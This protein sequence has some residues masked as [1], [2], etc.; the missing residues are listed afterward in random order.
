[1]LRDIEPQEVFLDRLAQKK[2]TDIK[3]KF[4][5]A[6]PQ[7]NVSFFFGIIILLLLLAV[8]KSFQ[9][10]VLEHQDFSDLAK[11][12]SERVYQSSS[13]RGIIYDR[14]MVQLVWNK[15]A[16]DL[17]CDTR[18]LPENR[19]EIFSKISLILGKNEEDIRSKIEE[20]DFYQVE[21]EDNLS[22]EA[23]MQLEARIDEFKGFRIEENTVREYLD[24]SLSHIL[25]YTRKISEEELSESQGYAVTD[26][27]GKSGLEEWY[28]NELRGVPAKRIIQKDASGRKIGEV[29]VSEA[30]P[31]EN[32]VL[33]LDYGLQKKIVEELEKSMK[34]I[35]A[36]KAAAIAMDPETGGVLAL[37]SI[38]Y[39]DNNLFS[40]GISQEDWQDL[41]SSP[42]DPLFNKAVSGIGYPTG[43]TIKPIVGMAALEEGIISAET[44]ID[45]PS[46]VCIWNPY[47][48]KDEC[49]KDWTYPQ[50]HGVSDIKRAIAESVNPFFYIIGGGYEGFSGLGA[51]KILEYFSL[52]GMG[53]K[54]GIDLPSEGEGV[55]PEIDEDWRLGNTYHLSIGQGAFTA[56]PLEVSSALA[57]IANGGKLMKPSLVQK[58]PEII[59]ENFVDEGNI[60]TIREGMRQTVSSGSAVSLNSLAVEAAAKTGTA[61][62]SLEGHYHHWI[63]VF[64][65]YEDPEIILTLIIEDVEGIQ[66]VTLPAAKEILDWYF[67]ESE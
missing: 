11:A 62:S 67:E 20:S 56:T 18:D 26:Y 12:N 45:C 54:T 9:L 30:E 49:Y 13:I 43:S 10:Q 60:E 27:I 41:I 29:Q 32:L 35:G 6:L 2:E 23:L 28:E 15:P 36:E 48:L 14:D 46:Q 7:R 3:K 16:F 66:S 37:V 57:S 34:R 61:Q 65:P 42:F 55:L 25:G 33:N 53:E 5:V 19:A 24:P 50:A 58:E 21:I 59:K 1:M 38:P 63:S 52:F 44:T 51:E 4:E 39:F 8:G 40:Q 31:G 47:S 64:A 17:V 22:H